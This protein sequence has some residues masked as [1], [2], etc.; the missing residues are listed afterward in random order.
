LLHSAVDL[1]AFAAGYDNI[2]RA[3]IFETERALATRTKK[4]LEVVQDTAVEATRPPADVRQVN[5]IVSMVG[6]KVSD[7]RRAKGLSLQQLAAVSDVSPA[8]IHKIERSGMV[9][10]ITTLLKLATALGV[11]V[12][13]FVE[14]D[15]SPQEPVHFTHSSQRQR[16]YTP[17][18]GLRL[19]GITGSYRQF[20]AAAAVA[21]MDPGANSGE[22]LLNHPGEELVHVVAGEAVF[23]VNGREYNLKAGDSLQF[24]G[25]VP[26]H[27]ENQ[28]KKP[29]DLIWVVLRNG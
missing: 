18:K 27:W 26:H 1:L 13:Y 23:R 14:E 10:T 2:C 25:N 11:S 20:Q 4:K 8:A 22:K 17:H 24:N 3:S 19:A 5:D 29:A 6:R 16:I 15:E 7:L 21:R 28:S 12:S 9:P